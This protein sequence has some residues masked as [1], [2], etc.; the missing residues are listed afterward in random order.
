M[1]YVA[2]VNVPGYL[3]ES[4]SVVFDTPEEA[5]EYLIG[6]RERDE[7]TAAPDDVTVAQL[8]VARSIGASGHIYGPTPGS[9]SPHDLGL[10]YC[11]TEISDQE[12]AEIDAEN[13]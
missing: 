5:W 13:E 1:K 6:E 11:V 4:D 2:S 3:P 10:A 8:R 12:A 7:D 9:D